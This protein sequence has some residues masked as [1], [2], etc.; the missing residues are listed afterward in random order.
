LTAVLARASIGNV[1]ELEPHAETR[2]TTRAPTVATTSV[3]GPAALATAIGNRAMARLAAGGRVLSRTPLAPELQQSM[4]QTGVSA[5][6]DAELDRR[7]ELL[8]HSVPEI[9]AGPERDAAEVNLA[10]LEDEVDSR[11]YES[12]V[13]A[14][15]GLLGASKELLVR[16]TEVE[17]VFAALKRP[18]LHNNGAIQ[19]FD[20]RFY[21]P[22]GQ[23]LDWIRKAAT[24][25][26]TRAQSAPRD[27]VDAAFDAF[28]TAG[29]ELVAATFALQLLGVWLAW[30]Q[31]A[32]VVLRQVPPYPVE[33]LLVMVDKQAPSIKPPLA[34]LASLDPARVDVA[35]VALPP[36]LDALIAAHGTV[37]DE[38]ERAIKGNEQLQKFMAVYELVLAL[39]TLRFP[40]GGAGAAG[41]GGALVSAGWVAGGISGGAMVGA[42]LV[43]TVEWLEMIR[44]LIAAG[45]IALPVAAAGVRAGVM[46]MAAKGSKAGINRVQSAGAIIRRGSGPLQPGRSPLGKYGI[47]RYG[48]YSNRPGDKLAGHELL[49]N[50][51]LEVKGF[52]KRLASAA[53]RDNPAVGLTH[54][55]HAEVGR[56][57]RALGLFDRTQL[58]NMGAQDVIDQNALA[59]RRA[60]IPNDVIE[61]L[62]REAMR[63]AASLGF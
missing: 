29:T 10:L 38:V 4:S 50:L 30:L 46:M 48:S 16:I 34:E 15:E 5:L 21:T 44:R 57:Q 53:S 60:G 28:G 63:H 61:T 23:N 11:G 49:E 8:M 39:A 9:S 45:V 41:A 14:R 18:A 42:R 3:T 54:A 52:G 47:D 19:L 20:K 58:A 1:P 55:E 7:I 62:R 17:A 43:V 35:A 32:D 27:D 40:A 37:V 2:E 24:S 33:R 56:Q 22:A 25:A 12:P 31:L 6:A 36:L 26:S 13:L 51:W 59:M